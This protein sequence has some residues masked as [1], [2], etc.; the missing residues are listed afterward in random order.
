MLK[1]Y[2]H[3]LSTIEKLRSGSI[4][5]GGV[6]LGKTI[7]ALAYYFNKVCGGSIGDGQH[8]ISMIDPIDLYVITTAAKR[9]KKEWE[10][11]AAEFLLE[12]YNINFVVDSWNNIAKYKGVRGS[13]IIFDEQRV[14]GKGKWVKSFLEMA[15]RNQWILL[16]ATPGDVWM[17][18]IPV[19]IA[20]G[21]IKNRT[22]FN[23]KYVLAWNP[24]TTF[25][26]PTRFNDEAL[27]K[28]R[29]AILVKMPDP[30]TTERHKHYIW[31]EYNKELYKTILR[32]RWDPYKDEPIQNAAGVC[33]LL[34]KVVN[35]DE[36][37]IAQLRGLLL[38]MSKVIIFYNFDYE[39]ELIRDAC[40]CLRLNHAEWNGHRHDPIPDT[41]EWVYIVQYSAGSEGWNCTETNIIIFYSLNY[42][43]RSMEQASGRIDRM[44]TRFKDLD[45][46][47]LVS[48]STID[49]AI[50]KAIDK[51]KKFNAVKFVG[52]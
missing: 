14:V 24:F 47:I 35:S 17:D 38:L 31:C 21:F 12:T 5:Y 50:M 13:F 11:D 23:M 29:D 2:P 52:G 20:N 34:R 42:S 33:Y 28:F 46:Y 9:D 26:K 30:R 36:S 3:Q 39:L 32:D 8:Y 10:T 48:K 16:T 43:Y 25:P 37:R 22:E 27:E 41:N 44:N 15:K 51:K 49:A 40:E 6:G 18:Y 7:T 45:Y 4:L 19:F 1:L